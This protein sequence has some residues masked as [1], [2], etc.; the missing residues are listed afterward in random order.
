MACAQQCAAEYL[1]NARKDLVTNLQDFP[2]II[3]NLYQR[4]V[5]NDYEV[6][7]LKAERAD[8]DKARFIL[9]T[10]YKKGESASYELLRILNISRTKTLHPDSHIWISCFPFREDTEGDCIVGTKPCHNYQMQLKTKAEKILKRHWEQC[11]KYLKNKPQEDFAY[12]PVVLDTD[13]EMNSVQNKIKTKNRK[14]KK[15]RHKKLKSYIPVQK[16]KLTPGDLLNSLRK[17]VLLI[18]KPGIGKTSVVLEMLSLWSQ[19]ENRELDYMFYFDEATLSQIA[20]PISLESLLFDLCCKPLEKDRKE[21]LQ[22]IEENSE[23][24]I[25]VFDGVSTLKNNQVLQ[26]IMNIDLLPDAKIVMTCRSD[27]EDDFFF[28]DTSL[29]KV[30]VQGFSEESV[31]VYFKQMIGSDPELLSLVLNNQEL[32]SLCHVPMYA[33]MVAACI[34]FR[35]PT[36]PRCPLTVT[37]M[38][39]HI[40]RQDLKK[41]GNKTSREVD[42]YIKDMRDELSSLMKSAFNAALQRTVN[43]SSLHCDETE[44]SNVFLKTIT[45]ED[46]P[47]SVKQYHAFLHS[48]VQ[49]F[50][51][52][53]WLLGNPGEIDKVLQLCQT[54]EQKHLKHVIPFFCGL[55]SN[56]NLELLKN[57][58]LEDQIKGASDKFFMKLMDSF[59]QPPTNTE[60]TDHEDDAD[61][62]FLCQCLYESQSL[63]A[64]LLFLEK[65]NYHL[66]LSGNDL[67]PHQCCAVCYVISQ[68]SERQVQLSL[69]DCS[70]SDTGIQMILRITPH[71]RCKSSTLCHLWMSVLGCKRPRDY[72]A[73]LHSCGK[74]LHLPVFVEEASVL[75]KAGLI[76][77]EHFEKINLHLHCDEDAQQ[78]S[79]ALCN[80][81][82]EALPQINSLRFEF[83]DD[84]RKLIETRSQIIESI[85]RELVLRGAVFEE[86][87]IAILPSVLRLFY[88][89]P[90]QV[91]DFLLKLPF[92]NMED[93]EDFNSLKLAYEFIPSVWYI[94]LSARKVSL[95]LEVLKLQKVKKPVEL[96]GWLDEESDVRSF[97]QCLPYISQ[98]RFTS[99]ESES[100]KLREKVNLF[101]LDL[102]L[103]AALHHTENIHTAVETLMSCTCETECD[104]L[105][106]LYSHVKNYEI[107]TGRSVLPVLQPVYESAPA[108][109]IIN[110]SERK[111]S[112]FLEVLKLQ[113]VKRPVELRGW[114]DEESE[115][116]S[117]L[118]CLPYI[119]Q[120]RGVSSSKQ[121]DFL[122]DLYMHVKN[123]ETQ[124]GRSVLPA[125]QPV[126]QSAPAVWD[127]NLSERKSSLFLEV[128]KLQTVKKPVE[129][130]GWS[131]EE[132][133]VRS[134]L[135]CLPYIAQ[136]RF[137]SAQSESNEWK[138]RVNSF[139]QDLCLQAALH[140]KDG[141]HTTVEKLMACS[142]GTEGD[143]LLDLYSH[144]KNYESQTGRSVLPALQPVYQSAPAVWNINLSERKSSLFLEVL[145]L[146]TEKKPVELRGWSDEESEVR[147]FVQC[148][149]YISQLRISSLSIGS[150][151]Q[152]FLH[153]LIKAAECE[154]QTGEKILE[155]LTSVCTYSSFP[156]GVPNSYKQNDFLLG[157]FSCVKNYDTQT[158]RSVLPALQPVYQ[159][160]PAVWNINLSERNSSLFLEVLKLQKVKKPVELRGWS[161]E[162]SEVRSFLQCLPYISQLRISSWSD[163]N[164]IQIFLHMLI[165]AAECERQNGEKILELL[166]SVCTYSSFPYEYAHN[167]KQSDFLLDLYSHVRGYQTQT[168]RSV[169][170]A[171]QPVYQSAP[172][173]W[174]IDLSERKSSLLLEVLKLQTVKKPVELRGWSDEESEVRSFLQCLPYISQLRFCCKEQRSVFQ[175]LVKLIVAAAEGDKAT[176]QS[177]IKL[178]TSV[179]SY[180]TL[181]YDEYC[182][183][184]NSSHQSDFLLYLYSHVKDY[185]TQTGRSVLPAL[186]PVYQSAPAVWNI[187]L[188]ERKSSLLLEVLKLQ[189]EKKPIE[190]RGWSDE[191]SEVRSF[192]QC[193]PYISQLRLSSGSDIS[194]NILLFLHVLIEAA[195]CERQT[196]EKTLQLLIS[197]CTYSSFP[198]GVTDSSKQSDFLLDLYSR[199]KNYETQTGRTPAVWNINLSERK[200]SLLLEVL[201]LQTVKKPVELRGWSD[202]ESE[203]RSFLQCLPYISQLSG[204]EH[205][206]PSLCKMTHSK[207]EAEQVAS[208]LQALNFTLSLGGK[209]SITS[210]RSVGR[211]LGFSASSLNLTLNP[212]TI[213]LR[214]ARLLFRHITHIRTLRLNGVMMLRM[215]RALRA[216]KAPT[217]V[218]IEELTLILNRTQWSVG[219]L[220][221]VLSSLASLLRLWKIQCV[222]LTEHT[223][224]VQSLTVLLSHQGSVAIRLSKETLQQL[225]VLVY[226]TKEEEFTLCFLQKVGGDLTSC[227]LNWEMIQYFLQYHMIIVDF[228]KSNIKQHNI[229]E[230]LSVLDRIQFRRLSSSFV[231]SIIREIYETGSV[232]CVSSLLSSAE[233]CINLNSRELDFL[234]CAALRLTL[235]HCTAVSL[236][237]LWTSIPE[238]E[239]QSFVLL[240]NHISNLSVDRLMLLKLLYCCSVSKGTAAA[241]LLSALQHR[242][243]FSCSSNLDLTVRTHT[244]ALSCEDCRVIS[245]TIQRVHANVELIL[246]DCET[247]EAGVDQLFTILHTVRLNCSK[248]LL[249]QFLTLLH[250]KTGLDCVRL[251]L[252]LSQALG[253]EVDLS[254]TRLDLVACKSI[255]L[256]LVNKGVVFSF[257]HEL[258]TTPLVFTRYV[259]GVSANQTWMQP[260]TGK[261]EIREREGGGR[262]HDRFPL[263]DGFIEGTDRIHTELCSTSGYVDNAEIQ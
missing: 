149:P 34:S 172:A 143:F 160:A 237:L 256:S 250:R 59:F 199:V 76:I 33:S 30:Y 246:Q 103:Q 235:Q 101:L 164:D 253:N 185:E 252:A 94:D 255:K 96:R 80:M 48:T 188:S 40:L 98:L 102:C 73:L 16:Q 140:L 146:Q 244:L 142:C 43:I 130:R 220:S 216:V 150:D 232:H 187:N 68:S 31:Q 64:C 127:V 106:D 239:L 2:L 91:C 95:F 45:T 72:T 184:Y 217:P 77:T 113:T 249:L 155:L 236:S 119:S 234:Q 191:E 121:S 82:F 131:D 116:K 22:D 157:L 203:A 144:V 87:Q 125:L 213:S 97:L 211:V 58:F 21:V 11:C 195:E 62:V 165:K 247:E 240:L 18:G 81:I 156:Y 145:K 1:G 85:Q 66:D 171:L 152:M 194:K 88:E 60:L 138:K 186:Q 200:S 92:L 258:D 100:D 84:S 210:C 224:E 35:K 32:F 111:S 128:L 37:E 162:E 124:T 36:S 3:E 202:E 15:L 75:R 105:L 241:A 49:E 208:L 151:V 70:I 159:S 197:V 133:E 147:T 192:L 90:F 55:L 182:Y 245:S 207:K 225:A 44:I 141:I 158:G 183:F 109:W 161:D 27:L 9:D 243:D 29:C 214:G 205:S 218:T 132:S 261:R 204:A 41:A 178:L 20:N 212:Q 176:Q 189:T 86:Q 215:V 174:Y 135:Q 229:R 17:A 166:T 262:V 74:Q 233:N 46:S 139:L 7:A 23:N 10:V 260:Q 56:Q 4:S 6:D 231:L 206:V 79:D 181:L 242:L 12:V 123:Y 71:L 259:I 226:E 170:P 196:G 61:A 110:L 8:F 108:V 193:L 118:Q 115:V 5:F 180:R 209:L 104:F 134:F 248:V 51:A 254:Q 54:E 14:C 251:A 163:S 112:L 99:P 136:L 223:M 78:L 201:K 19:K 238:G 148:L 67:D 39:V 63:E 168:G 228:R 57:L 263:L 219:E 53:L 227:S 154:I 25:I 24:V 257:Y 222:N 65:V 117:F 28:P 190:L 89:D 198:Y 126:Y 169:L 179:C 38:Y 175:F 153:V 107:Q 129:L 173:V 42:K 122:L 114:S 120:L 177:F 47:T 230:L 93:K 167:S 52:A 69:E 137:S 221:R 83:P 50:F 13:T 26:K